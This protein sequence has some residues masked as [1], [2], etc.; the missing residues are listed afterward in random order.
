MGGNTFS[1]QLL[2]LPKLVEADPRGPHLLQNLITHTQPLWRESG[3]WIPSAKLDLELAEALKI[4]YQTGQVIRGLESAEQ[5]LA[6]EERGLRMA[7]VQSGVTRGVRVSRLLIL[8]KDG[9]QRFYR[10]VETMLRR[11]GPRVL[12]IRLEIDEKGL[13]E[14]LFGPDQ[15]ARLVMLEHKKAVA[16]VLLAMAGQWEDSEPLGE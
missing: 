5:A 14:L 6:T 10:N 1:N 4:A 15:V 7:D 13:G 2:R 12:A 11:H 9:A 8:A 16:S 3:L